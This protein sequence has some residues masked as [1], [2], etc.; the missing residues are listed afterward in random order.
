MTKEKAKHSL[1][2]TDAVTITMDWWTS[3]RNESCLAVTAHYIN[4]DMELKYL[5]LKYG[6]KH[7]AINL[8][9]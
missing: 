6:E 5:L 4:S 8:A 9:Q 7:T 3:V 2:F 1:E